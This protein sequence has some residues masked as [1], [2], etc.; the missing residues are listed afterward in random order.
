MQWTPSIGTTRGGARKGIPSTGTSR[1]QSRWDTLRET[2]YWTPHNG[3]L[4]ANSSRVTP[5]ATPSIRPHPG[6]TI[7]GK[8]SR[9]HRHETP[10]SRPIQRHRLEI[11][12]RGPHPWYHLQG[13]PHRGNNK[14]VPHRGLPGGQPAGPPRG[15]TPEGHP[16]SSFGGRDSGSQ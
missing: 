15:T 6:D 2:L 10:S 12:S 3:P 5:R 8:T 4:P 9:G 7:K 11:P 1:G 13:N 14:G 16:R